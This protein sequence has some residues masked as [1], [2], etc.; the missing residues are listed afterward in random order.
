MRGMDVGAQPG[1]RV[2]WTGPRV[3]GLLRMN[4]T[5]A[6]TSARKETVALR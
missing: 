5:H 2:R 6:A 3:G 1:G 4:R